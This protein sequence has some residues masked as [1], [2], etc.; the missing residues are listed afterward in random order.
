MKQIFLV[1]WVMVSML[2]AIIYAN[3]ICISAITDCCV[4]LD[5]CNEL[6]WITK[7]KNETTFE[8]IKK[9]W[10]DCPT[11]GDNFVKCPS[12]EDESLSEEEIEKSELVKESNSSS[13]NG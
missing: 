6:S 7:I 3:V 11:Q 8:N 13:N 10:F 5:E 4:E 9:K 2:Y 12:V 1:F